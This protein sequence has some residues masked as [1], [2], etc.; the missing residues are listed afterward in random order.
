MNLVVEENTFILWFVC[1]ADALALKSVSNLLNVS[2]LLKKSLGGRNGK[3]GTDPHELSQTTFTLSTIGK[4]DKVG[5]YPTS[6][7]HP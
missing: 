6:T 1:F 3:H 5:S 4:G 2:L 7:S